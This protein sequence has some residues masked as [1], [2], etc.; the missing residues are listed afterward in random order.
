M[1]FA[2]LPLSGFQAP[3][4]PDWTR[5][6][7]QANEF[8]AHRPIPDTASSVSDAVQQINQIIKQ[9][10]PEARMERTL[11]MEMLKSHIGMYQQY[12]QHPEEFEFKNGMLQHR[13]KY[14]ALMD[15]LR[16]SNALKQGKLLDDRINAL[17][18]N[19][20]YDARRRLAAG[21]FDDPKIPA[22]GSG[23]PTANGG[24]NPSGG[25]S[26]QSPEEVIETGG[27]DEDTGD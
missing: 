17:G 14:K 3:S 18:G 1:P 10:S 21:A 13:D 15:G 25:D 9:Q 26:G 7:A 4:A 11:K 12:K 19:D 8:I 6:G 16:F 27:S 22:T 2:N 5:F 20:G 23:S 24:D